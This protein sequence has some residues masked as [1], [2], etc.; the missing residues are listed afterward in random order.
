MSRSNCSADFSCHDKECLCYRNAV[1]R[2]IR[3][4]RGQ[5]LLLEM[6]TALDAMPEKALIAGE[7]ESSDGRV[8][9]LGCV[10]RARGIDMKPLNPEHI[11]QIAKAFDIAESQAREIAYMN[12]VVGPYHETPEQRWRLMR[13]WV[14]EQIAPEVKR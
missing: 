3:G 11:K 7:L 9:A 4:K 6:L 2:A 5:A 10:G 12:D 1:D 14:Q 13:A 8:C